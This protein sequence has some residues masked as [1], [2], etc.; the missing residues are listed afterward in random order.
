MDAVLRQL[1]ELCSAQPTRPK[2]VFVPSHALGHT[3]GERL[4]R[5]GT[6]WANLRFTPPFDVALQMAAPFLIERGIEPAADEVG[7]ALVMR[8]LLDLPASVPRYFRRLAEQPQMAE[9]LWTT[10]RELRMAD[11]HAS[12]LEP[13][14]FVSREKHTELTALLAAYEA[15][16][17]AHRLAD[18][19]DVYREA[20]THVDL[21]PVLPDDVRL[22]WPG[23]IWSPLEQRFLTALGGTRLVSPV[24]P[25]PGLATPRRLAT[26]AAAEAP[27][28][29]SD[30]ER[31]VYLLRPA[32]A[33]PA[34]DDESLTMFRAGGRQ[35][36]VEE[37][38]RRIFHG[39][40]PLDHV[41]VACAHTES[42]LL[43]WEKAQRY[44]VPV[45]AGPGL[46][47]L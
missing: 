42:V 8:L 45:T 21:G 27:T 6:A 37:V 23:V 12:A 32:D 7:P 44:G 18:A 16:L 40:I 26:S 4:V 14:A 9:A 2:W 43:V 35:A 1:A 34:F 36:E 33:P 29:A 39:A 22:E 31:L 25:V 41:E 24:M 10:I 13:D 28:P 46:P 19:A 38:L 15:H 11:V 17:A 30:A 3:I 47:R 5:S 20:V